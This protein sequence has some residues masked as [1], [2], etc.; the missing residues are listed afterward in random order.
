MSDTA[1]A[2]PIAHRNVRALLPDGMVTKGIVDSE[3]LRF[4]Y[5]AWVSNVRVA[6]V[7]DRFWIVED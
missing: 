1:T 4:A 5:Y 2:A 6:K 7:V 3:G